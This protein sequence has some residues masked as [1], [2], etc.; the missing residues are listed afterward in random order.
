MKV[1]LE[2][3]SRILNVF[4]ESDQ[5][6]ITINDIGNSG[7]SLYKP[8][9]KG[10]EEEFLFH[11]QNIVEN[12]LI[13]NRELQCHGLVSVGITLSGGDSVTIF[14]ARIRLTQKGH[15]FAKALNNKEV[16]E[17][18]KG[19]FK[20]APFKVVFDGGQK[21]LEHFFKKKIDSILE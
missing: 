3:L 6:H 4:L 21:L 9:N 8:D 13:S 18:L 16:L 2:Y 20:N 17:K 12:G 1:N 10:L 11:I 14:P 15:D 5:A 7:I 19:E